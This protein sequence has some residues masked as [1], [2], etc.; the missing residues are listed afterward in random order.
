MPFLVGNFG[1]EILLVLIPL[2]F[3]LSRGDCRIWNFVGFSMN[4]NSDET[5]LI[6]KIQIESK[7]LQLLKN[8]M[9]FN[10]FCTRA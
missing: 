3:L 4:L 2:K 8:F 1:T 10:H 6:S 5:H 7:V 9:N